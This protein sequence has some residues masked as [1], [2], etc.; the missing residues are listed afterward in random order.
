M[1]ILGDPSKSLSPVDVPPW[2]AHTTSESKFIFFSICMNLQKVFKGS[3]PSLYQA[4]GH[5]TFL[6]TH[7]LLY[8]CAFSVDH[9]Y[10]NVSSLLS[11]VCFVSYSC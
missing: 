4:I 6:A 11:L 2:A 8:A 3:C 5:C 7:V 1:R 10:F 9:T